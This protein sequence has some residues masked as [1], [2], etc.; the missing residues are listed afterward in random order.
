MAQHISLI[1]NPIFLV[2]AERSGTTLLR[3]MLDHHPQIAFQSE[4]E[5]A[6]DYFREHNFPVLNEYYKCLETNRLF[7]S[8]DFSID[9][10]LD[11]PQLINSFLVQKRDRAGKAFVGATVHRHFDRLL[12]IWS[13]ARFIHIIRDGRDVTR[14]CIGMKWAGNV[15]TG[16]DR[17]IEAE[18]LWS[19]LKATIS[20]E[21]YTEVHYETLIAEPVKTLTH[22][23][24]FIGTSYDPAML[25]YAQTTTYDLPNAKLLWQWKRKLSE[26]EIQLV[27]AKI[28]DMLV[29][30]G[31]ELSGLPSLTINSV[32]KQMLRL[33]N[34]LS[35]VQGRISTYGLPLIMSSVLSRHFDLKQWEKHVQ[36]KC[37]DIDAARLK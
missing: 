13:D 29:E 14:S 8:S 7:Q 19:Q 24:N 35:V 36:L 18:Q 23:C 12:Q 5:Y 25:S 27:E 34:K 1:S 6:V 26:R 16:I 32:T 31:Y 11:Y 15:W 2:G 37:N 9:F 21:Q 28:G 20:P 10:S 3:L 30:R 33:H 17:W 4:F 22:L